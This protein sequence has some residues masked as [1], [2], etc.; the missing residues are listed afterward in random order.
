MAR[1]NGGTG[2]LRVVLEFRSNGSAHSDYLVSE[3]RS[4]VQTRAGG[5]VQVLLGRRR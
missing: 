3:L 2:D 4:A 5:D 1:H